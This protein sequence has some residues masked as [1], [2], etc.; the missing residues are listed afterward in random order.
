MAMRLNK[1]NK[2]PSSTT[3][4]KPQKDMRGMTAIRK[5]EAAL[6]EERDE[7]LERLALQETQLDQLQQRVAWQETQ[8]RE[9]QNLAE[10]QIEQLQTSHSALIHALR[11]EHERA[12][13]S[14]T[15]AQ[16]EERAVWNCEKAELS[17]RIRSLQFVF[18]SRGFNSVTGQSLSSAESLAQKLQE[19]RT[20]ACTEAEKMMEQA[21]QGA[22]QLRTLLEYAQSLETKMASTSDGIRDICRHSGLLDVTNEDDVRQAH[23]F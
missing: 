18:E 2:P 9:Q 1:E 20:H 13:A 12:L 21:Q 14:M 4:A 22:E 6:R 3:K 23:H 17:A 10:Q 19:E 16:E 15:E 8:A 5:S 11:T 7:L